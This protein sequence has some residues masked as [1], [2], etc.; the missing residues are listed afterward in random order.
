MLRQTAGIS[1]EDDGLRGDLQYIVYGTES[2]CH[3][4]QLYVRL[5]LLGAVAK[6][7]YPHGIELAY[8]LALR[9][10]G[11]L[12][13]QAGQAAVHLYGLYYRGHIQQFAKSSPSEFWH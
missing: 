12:C 13:D 5:A 2:G 4:H 6:A 3:I 8:L 10:Y 9:H 11:L 7:R 1:V